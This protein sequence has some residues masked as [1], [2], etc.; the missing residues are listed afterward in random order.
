MSIDDFYDDVTE[1]IKIFVTD[2][3]KNQLFGE[4]FVNDSSR[5][6]LNLL[7]NEYMIVTRIA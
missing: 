6:I 7:F 5:E 4:I 1:K 2:D 3:K